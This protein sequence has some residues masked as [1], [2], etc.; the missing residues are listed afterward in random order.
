MVLSWTDTLMLGYFK[1]AEIVGIYSAIYPIAMLLSTGVDSLGYLYVPI[2]SRLYSENQ[3]QNIGKVNEISTKWGFVITVPVFFLIYVLPEFVVNTLYDYRY[4]EASNILQILALGF[5][6]NSLF[7]LNYYTL[8]ATG[9]ANFLMICSLFS[10]ALKI[11]LNLILIPS[12]GM[13]G[14]AIASII[15]YTTIEIYMT[16]KL[17]KFYKI[18]PFSSKYLKVILVSILLIGI[19]YI[20]RTLAMQDPFR[21]I[22]YYFFFLISYF[23]LILL[24]NSMDEEDIK[25]LQNVKNLLLRERGGARLP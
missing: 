20:F 5:M 2:I 16:L 3:V 18:H 24:T 9:K 1:T 14:A 10:A 21:I 13:I 23:V 7:G 11:I 15:S 4:I 17:Y 19:F 12:Y 25:I 22:E 6:M 8:M